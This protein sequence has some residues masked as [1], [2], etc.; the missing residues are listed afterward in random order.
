MT[1]RWADVPITSHDAVHI[2]PCSHVSPAVKY[3]GIFLNDEQPGLAQWANK[4][5]NAGPDAL[6]GQ[7]FLPDMYGK[8]F[9]LVL[10][11]KGNMIWPA[12][13]SLSRY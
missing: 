9:E 5:F 13:V 3:R 6:L 12:M 7:S 11:M 2:K 10:R 8:L 1:V 4:H